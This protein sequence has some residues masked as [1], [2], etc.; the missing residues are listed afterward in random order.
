MPS[1]SGSIPD[2]EHALILRR[3]WYFIINTS[4]YCNIRQTLFINPVLR[5]VLE[6]AQH[7]R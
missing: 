2:H 4:H 1:P 6:T 5:L 3:H 7:R